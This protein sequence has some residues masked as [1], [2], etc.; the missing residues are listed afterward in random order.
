MR[1]VYRWPLPTAVDCAR[2]LSM[3][4]PGHNRLDKPSID[5]H[6]AIY[7]SQSSIILEVGPKI[8]RGWRWFLLDTIAYPSFLLN[9]CLSDDNE[10]LLEH[11]KLVAKHVSGI[12]CSVP[13]MYVVM[14]TDVIMLWRPYAL[15]LFFWTRHHNIYIDVARNSRTRILLVTAVN[16]C[17]LVVSEIDSTWCPYFV[18]Y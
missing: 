11:T 6:L 13:G 3:A 14:C 8:Y 18:L 4:I 16:L 17:A 2:C 1:D 7:A 9:S 12:L 5:S 15:A 10:M